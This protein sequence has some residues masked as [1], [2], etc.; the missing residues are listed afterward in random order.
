MEENKN[1]ETKKTKMDMVSLKRRA[2][3]ATMFAMGALSMYVSLPTV[4]LVFIA[5]FIIPAIFSRKKKD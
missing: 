2:L 3:I 4:V 5:L 1:V